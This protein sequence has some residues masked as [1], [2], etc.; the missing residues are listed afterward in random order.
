MRLETEQREQR[1]KEEAEQR[2]QRIAEQMLRTKNENDLMLAIAQ[3]NRGQS[4]Q[5]TASVFH[6]PKPTAAKAGGSSTGASA[7]SCRI[8]LI[9]DSIEVST[10]LPVIQPLLA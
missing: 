8:D 3:A 9:D 6:R 4:S 1:L 10:T 5:Q 2:A 7:G